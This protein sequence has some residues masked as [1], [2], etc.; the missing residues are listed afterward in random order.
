MTPELPPTDSSWIIRS[1]LSGVAVM[2]L[3]RDQRRTLETMLSLPS[4][5]SKGLE[6]VTREQYEGE[7]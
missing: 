6:V 3:Q 1:K 5:A 7:R 4:F 2:E